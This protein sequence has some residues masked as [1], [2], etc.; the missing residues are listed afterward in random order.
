MTK[1]ISQMLDKI[2]ETLKHVLRA[3]TQRPHLMPPHAGL[4]SLCLSF[5]CELNVTI[6]PG[7]CFG[8]FDITR[9]LSWLRKN[10]SILFV[11]FTHVHV[12]VTGW[13]TT[14]K[15][16]RMCAIFFSSLAHWYIY[17]SLLGRLQHKRVNKNPKGVLTQQFKFKLETWKFTPLGAKGIWN[18]FR[19]S[20]VGND[21]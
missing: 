9:F 4:Y 18:L 21:I 13:K 17:S 5:F 20:P 15:L 14:G 12:R 10:A 1:L 16:R 6:T 7:Q 19:K 3:H 11:F 8:D 2:V